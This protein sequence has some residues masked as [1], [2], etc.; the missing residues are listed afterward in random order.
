MQYYQYLIPECS[1]H[2]RKNPVC[3]KLS[4]P[5]FP[6][7][8]R[9]KPL[10]HFLSPWICLL[11]TFYK[12]TVIWYV[13]FCI[14]LLSISIF[15]RFAHVGTSIS[16]SFL[17]SEENIDNIPSYVYSLIHRLWVVPTFGLLW[18]MLLWTFVYKFCENT[19]FHFS[20]QPRNEIA[21]SMI[22][23]CLTFW[24]ICQSFSKQLHHFT[25]PSALYEGSQYLHI[26]TNT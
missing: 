18:I 15:S 3:M 8:D 25:F 19:C 17:L 6:S 10:I 23:L 21:R 12:S 20:Y 9:H 11:Q 7:P 22:T 26:L 14:W 24:R 2:L 13:T 1:H 4:L 16:I 5:I